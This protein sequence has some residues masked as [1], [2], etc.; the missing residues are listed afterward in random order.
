MLKI[1]D[2]KFD[3]RSLGTEMLLVDIVP[4]YVWLNG[5]RTTTVTG[6]KYIIALPAHSL[7]K[8]AVKIDG[9]QKIELPEGF[10]KVQ[11]S[12]LELG[13]YWAQGAP[14]VSAKAQGIS[15]VKVA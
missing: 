15:L 8:L 14:Q 12:G 6:Y 1:T 9:E 11:F 13:I 2:L 3:H 4:A 7:E 10:A 5:Q